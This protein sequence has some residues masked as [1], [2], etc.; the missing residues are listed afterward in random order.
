MRE[1]YHLEGALVCLDKVDGLGE[2]VELET[3]AVDEEAI[4]QR[5]DYLIGTL[6]RL[7]VTSELIRESYLEMLLDKRC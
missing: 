3:L 2:F 5:R 7:G 6:R 1:I 4:P